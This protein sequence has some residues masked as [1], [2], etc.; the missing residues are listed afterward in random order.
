[1][2]HI[3]EDMDYHSIDESDGNGDP[4]HALISTRE[5]ASSRDIKESHTNKSVEPVRLGNGNW[6]CNHRCKDKTKYV[7]L[8]IHAIHAR[9]AT[10]LS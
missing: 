1:M 10:S 3:A 2:R 6:A 7:S 4:V 8:L 5:T 9:S